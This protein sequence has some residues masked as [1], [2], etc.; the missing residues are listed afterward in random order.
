MSWTHTSIQSHQSAHSCR[1]CGVEV[2]SHSPA[3]APALRCRS[4]L[5]NHHQSPTRDGPPSTRSK[6]RQTSRGVNQPAGRRKSKETH[7]SALPESAS[8]PGDSHESSTS[9]TFF[10]GSEA[11]LAKLQEVRRCQRRGQVPQRLLAATRARLTAKKMSR[12]SGLL[13]RMLC[14]GSRCRGGARDCR[15]GQHLSADPCHQAHRR[16]RWRTQRW[17]YFAQCQIRYPVWIPIMYLE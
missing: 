4:T 8:V 11:D 14:C 3:I 6:R 9:T 13:R 15:C 5:R 2:R 10:G 12:S 1:C 16:C 7:P 17:S